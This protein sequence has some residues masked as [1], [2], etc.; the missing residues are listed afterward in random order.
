[1]GIRKSRA[2]QDGQMQ[3]ESVVKAGHRNEAPQ[4]K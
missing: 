2:K 3:C 4:M 1:M